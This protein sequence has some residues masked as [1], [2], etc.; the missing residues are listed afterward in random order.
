[1]LIWNFRRREGIRKEAGQRVWA[2]SH[3]D[4][5]PYMCLAVLGVL[6][7]IS[8]LAD[9]LK[10][11]CI[12]WSIF[13]HE[14]KC[15]TLCPWGPSCKWS[16]VLLGFSS[17]SNDVACADLVWGV[18]VGGLLLGEYILLGGLQAGRCCSMDMASILGSFC[19]VQG[20]WEVGAVSN[21]E[22]LGED[23]HLVTVLCLEDLLLV[24]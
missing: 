9:A 15:K 4:S 18:Q 14:D 6:R 24:S 5:D 17:S 3:G 10:S 23:D 19:S 21:R 22:S 1:M 13:R 20:H 16:L 2:G 11:S 8:L 12:A 7:C